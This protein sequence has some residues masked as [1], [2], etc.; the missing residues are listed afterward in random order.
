MAVHP[1]PIDR[2]RLASM[3][4]VSPDDRFWMRR[5]GPALRF[6]RA[7]GLLIGSAIV[8]GAMLA[9]HSVESPRTSPPELQIVY[10]A[11]PLAHPAR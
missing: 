4:R 1:F 11:G 7:G 5:E 2:A 10:E 9:F 8:G 6:S 3:P